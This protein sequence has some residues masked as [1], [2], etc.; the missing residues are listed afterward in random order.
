M[1]LEKQVFNETLIPGRC[2]DHVMVKLTNMD[3]PLKD[4]VC[5]TTKRVSSLFY[6]EPLTPGME[7]PWFIEFLYQNNN[8]DDFI[9]RY[10]LRLCQTLEKG[11][12]NKMIE[13]FTGKRKRLF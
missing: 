4:R 13:E 7:Y 9:T 8:N 3:I 12:H 1:G 6:I 5:T 2:I 10:R 11:I